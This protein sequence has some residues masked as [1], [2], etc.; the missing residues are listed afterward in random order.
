M[1]KKEI[2]FPVTYDLKIIMTREAGDEEN[3][4]IVESVLN[5]LSINNGDWTNKFSSQGKYIRY[6][7]PITLQSQEQMHQLYSSLNNIPFIKFA[8]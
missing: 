4:R 6:S 3:R 5:N 7:I 8:L 1:T 2:K